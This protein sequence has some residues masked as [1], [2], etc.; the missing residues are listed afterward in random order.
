MSLYHQHGRK[1]HVVATRSPH[2][3][4]ARYPTT[5]DAC[6]IVPPITMECGTGQPFRG[7][8]EFDGDL[9]RPPMRSNTR[10]QAPLAQQRSRLSEQHSESMVLSRVGHGLHHSRPVCAPRVLVLPLSQARPGRLAPPIS[11]K[12]VCNLRPERNTCNW[13]DKK[14]VGNHASRSDGGSEILIKIGAPH[15][16]PISRR[17]A[18]T[19]DAS[20][21]GAF[22]QIDSDA[23]QLGSV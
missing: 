14:F 17:I 8:F 6:S 23:S 11:R 1:N 2:T 10:A 21:P 9:W 15:A 19:A 22:F 13:N 4:N 12:Y 5:L 16:R 20:V 3:A 7:S 18:S